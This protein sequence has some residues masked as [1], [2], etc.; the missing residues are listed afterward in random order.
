MTGIKFLT[1]GKGKPE[2]VLIDLKRHGRL[3]DDFYDKLLCE[4]RKNEPRVTWTAVKKR[5][6]KAEKARG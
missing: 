6:M 5:L 4:R 1:N 2:A 3:W